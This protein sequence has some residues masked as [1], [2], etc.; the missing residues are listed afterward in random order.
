MSDDDVIGTNLED[1]GPALDPPA[2]VAEPPVQ[3]ADAPEAPH[4]DKPA[5]VEAVEVAGQRYVPLAVLKTMRD[6]NRTLKEA[7]AR[8]DQL[9]ARLREI[10]PYAQFV[11]NNRDLLIQ[12]QAPDPAPAAPAVDPDALEAARLLDFYK[13]DGTPDTDKGA[14][15]LALQEK[16]SERI[17]EAR[18]RPLVQQNQQ[19]Q[20]AL[21]FQRALQ[22]KDPHG[23]S[24][25]R[26]T[27]QSLWQN[28][29]P[30]LVADER[31][32][33]F[34]A[35]TALG[36]DQMRSRKATVPVPAPALV[37]ETSGGNP[38]TRPLLSPLE[39]RIAAERGISQTKWAE[40]TRGYQAGK[41]TVLED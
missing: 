13:P 33:F 11:Q 26:E 7:A 15:W 10:E 27:L 37:T 24:P 35:N 8:A 34:L 3:E 39:E 1:D 5:E 9:E 6:E 4:E 36:M 32:A 40:H 31:V 19:D 25:S 28:M 18:I 41:P 20:A 12:R 22:M 23:N 38:R 30:E 17:A 16:R 14:R 2:P 29:T 21:N